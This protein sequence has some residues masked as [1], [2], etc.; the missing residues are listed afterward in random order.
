MRG[1]L[2]L[3]FLFASIA[4]YTQEAGLSGY[5]RDTDGIPVA[6]AAVT[7]IGTSLGA[8]S[9]S[10]G[11]YRIYRIS[12]GTYNLRAS[13]L[14]FE[15][16]ELPVSLKE[17]QNKLDITLAVSDINPGEVV[18]TAT[19]SERTIKDVP[20]LTQVINARQMLNLG[21]DNVP[22]ALQNMVPGLDVSQFGTRTSISM[23]GM[24]AKYVLFLVDGER[25]AGEI[26]GDIDYS[27]FNMENIEKIEVIKGASSSLYGS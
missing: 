14:G 5:I 10:K 17:G 22:D 18:V 11:Y 27:M 2:I 21:I 3:I 20:V 9:D 26:N 16:K 15:T 8:N 4:A 25:I 24:D 19:K 1:S 23:Q 12:P 7:I 13:L 6:G